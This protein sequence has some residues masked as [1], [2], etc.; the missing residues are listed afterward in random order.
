MARP[1]FKPTEEY[2]GLVEILAAYG[3]REE[4]IAVLIG[5]KGIGPKTLRKYF[6]AAL[7]TGASKAVTKV[8]QACYEMAISGKCP[9]ATLFWLKTQ[10]AWLAIGP[11][12]HLV[13]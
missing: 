1:R 3:E 8:A 9:A 7:D 11:P 10:A 12:R 2:R 5:E 13:T 6:R 4:D